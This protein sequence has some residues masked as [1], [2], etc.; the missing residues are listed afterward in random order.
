MFLNAPS[1]HLYC[2]QQGKQEWQ[3]LPLWTVQL[4]AWAGWGH[5]FSLPGPR[6]DP[7]GF[8]MPPFT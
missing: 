2:Q 5:L 7:R 3:G 1:I 6:A 4:L 8:K